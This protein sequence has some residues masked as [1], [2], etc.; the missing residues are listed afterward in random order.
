VEKLIKCSRCDKLIKPEELSENDLLDLDNV[1]CSV[2]KK[3]V[4]I[5]DGC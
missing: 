1:L 4:F 5:L 2:C 3:D